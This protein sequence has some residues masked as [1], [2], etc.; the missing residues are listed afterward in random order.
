L[1]S[2]SPTLAVVASSSPGRCSGTAA[3]PKRTRSAFL[4]QRGFSADLRLLLRLAF[5][6]LSADHLGSRAG[7]TR[8]SSASGTACR[9]CI[10]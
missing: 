3:A 10:P 9:R 6:T 4:Y 7:R 8:Q 2:Q 5:A 1:F